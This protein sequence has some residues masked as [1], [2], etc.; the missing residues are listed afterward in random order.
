[1]GIFDAIFHIFDPLVNWLFPKEKFRQSRRGGPLSGTRGLREA[2]GE[3]ARGAIM[4]GRIAAMKRHNTQG[5][6]E[7]RSSFAGRPNAPRVPTTAR[8][9]SSSHLPRAR[10]RPHWRG[11]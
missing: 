9:V 3:R 6:F 1:M 10:H 4:A 2:T 5:H 11:R 7:G 8:H